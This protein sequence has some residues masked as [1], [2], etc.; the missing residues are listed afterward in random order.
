VKF[1]VKV[2]RTFATETHEITGLYI[3]EGGALKLYVNGDIIVAYA[4][5]GWVRLTREEI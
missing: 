2:T 4:P 3:S 1:R 5:Q